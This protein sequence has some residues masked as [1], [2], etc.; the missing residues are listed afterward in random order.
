MYTRLVNTKTKKTLTLVVVLIVLSSITAYAGLIVTYPILGVITAI[1][2]PII[3]EPLAPNASVGPNATSGYVKVTMV[4]QVLDLIRN[5]DF[6][7]GYGAWFYGEGDDD[8]TA[9]GGN[10]RGWWVN[11]TGYSTW[12]YVLLGAVN[13]T[14]P[15]QGYNY[16]IE[17]I[18]YPCTGLLSANLSFAY[19]TAAYYTVSGWFP[20]PIIYYNISVYLV[21]WTD[22]TSQLITLYTTSFYGNT[23]WTQVSTDVTTQLSNLTPGTYSIAV[24]AI[25]YFDVW[26]GSGN[27]YM[28][29][30]FDDIHLNVSCVDATWSGSLWKVVDRAGSYRVG[31]RLLNFTVVNGSI[32]SLS[33]YI[34]NGRYITT[35]IQVV[36]N[37]VT[38]NETTYIVF[39]STDT[40]TAN[41]TIDLEVSGTVDTIANM[42][43][44][45]V[46][47]APTTSIGV[48]VRYPLT[49]DIDPIATNASS[50]RFNDTIIVSTNKTLKPIPIRYRGSITIPNSIVIDTLW[51]HRRINITPR[52]DLESIRRYVEQLIEEGN[53][54]KANA[55]N[56]SHLTP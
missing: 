30:A 39:N 45:L 14:D 29:A 44:E 33:L 37:T 32:N 50:S 1:E 51:S 8:G 49:I 27:A 41:G 19:A 3:L 34:R 17:N 16:I 21:N 26:L 23:S 40:L 12:G 15:Y 31:L 5:G 47:Y 28:Y 52:I 42:S 36:N 43:V 24:V 48:L 11:A 4:Q 7:D 9:G 25:Y 38:N 6:I 54:T 46:Y 2:P 53:S 22:N 55:G 56:F 18:T 13:I 10:L 35:S 20:I